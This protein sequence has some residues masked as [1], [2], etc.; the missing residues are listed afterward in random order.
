MSP[1]SI[2]V[3]AKRKRT[4]LDLRSVIAAAAITAA[5]A[6]AAVAA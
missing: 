6:V 2:S 5:A 1:G 3:P 4:A